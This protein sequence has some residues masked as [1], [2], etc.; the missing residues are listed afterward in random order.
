MRSARRRRSDSWCQRFLRVSDISSPGQRAEYSRRHG[1]RAGSRRCFHAPGRQH[2]ASRMQAERRVAIGKDCWRPPRSGGLQFAERHDRQG[3]LPAPSPAAFWLLQPAVLTGSAIR[4][5]HARSM[6]PDVGLVMTLCAF[7]ATA[8]WR[9]QTAPQ[10]RNL[11][12]SYA[13]WRI[14][15]APAAPRVM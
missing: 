1:S 4:V 14:C 6:L 5:G 10:K 2:S 9:Q 12:A 13:S 11:C 7:A 15:A 3:S 8:A